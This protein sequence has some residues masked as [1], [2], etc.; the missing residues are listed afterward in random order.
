MSLRSLV[1][2]FPRVSRDVVAMIS[3]QVDGGSITR[4][5]ACACLRDM[6]PKEKNEK[7]V[8]RSLAGLGHPDPAPPHS[9]DDRRDR[10]RVGM[11]D[12]PHR[13]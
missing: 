10:H 3:E 1:A 7:G 6:Q 13:N 12:G 2:E 9:H 5:K 11:F 4:D 8:W